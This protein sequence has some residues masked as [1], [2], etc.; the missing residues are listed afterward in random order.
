MSWKWALSVRAVVIFT[1][2]MEVWKLAKWTLGWF[3][4]EENED[5]VEARKKDSLS[6]KQTFFSFL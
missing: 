1:L 4:A 6:L 5:D 2:G 3:T